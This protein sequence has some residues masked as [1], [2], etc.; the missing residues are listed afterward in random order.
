MVSRA[1]PSSTS[2]IPLPAMIINKDTPKV[3]LGHN[4][5]VENFLVLNISFSLV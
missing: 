4:I 5:T 2:P 3:F 1:F